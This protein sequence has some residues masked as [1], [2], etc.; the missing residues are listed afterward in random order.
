MDRPGFTLGSQKNE[1]LGFGAHKEVVA[2]RAERHW[3]WT[4]A[5]ADSLT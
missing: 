3:K 5:T 2:K 1:D 4:I